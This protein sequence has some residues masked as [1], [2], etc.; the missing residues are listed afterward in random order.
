MEVSVRCNSCGQD[1]VIRE[2]YSR[3]GEIVIR[4]DNCC[5]CIKNAKESGESIAYV[6]GASDG[7][8]QCQEDKIENKEKDE[9]N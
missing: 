1:L 2:S 3:L 8:A 4:V 5:R 9:T 7:Y 6:E